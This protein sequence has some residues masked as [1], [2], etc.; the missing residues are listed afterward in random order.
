M[1][2]RKFLVTTAATVALAGAAGLGH[3]HNYQGNSNGGTP[4]S[5]TEV[6][7]GIGNLNTGD[8]PS[9]FRDMNYYRE[10]R[11][12]RS[13]Y[14]NRGTPTSGSEVPGGIG[15]PNPGDNLRSNFPRQ[16]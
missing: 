12:V 11:Y 4:I 14:W 2:I 3:A 15:N 6:P 8:N 5:G 9:S 1:N 10:N 7:G 16:Y 13:N